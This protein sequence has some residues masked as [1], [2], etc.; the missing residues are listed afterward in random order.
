MST[1]EKFS[2]NLNRKM[3]EMFGEEAEDKGNPMKEGERQG[4]W[5]EK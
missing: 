3:R 4:I 2:F 5:L 1:S